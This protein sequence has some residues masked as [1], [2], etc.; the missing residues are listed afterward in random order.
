MATQK[1]EVKLSEDLARHF[2][3]SKEEVEASLFEDAIL[4]LLSTGKIDVDEAAK[5]LHCDPDQLLTPEE[6]ARLRLSEE[7]SKRG[8]VV[9]LD[10]LRKDAGLI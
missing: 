6:E 9:S 10:Q 4:S 1:Y 7:Q 5:L 8:E 2:G 3:N